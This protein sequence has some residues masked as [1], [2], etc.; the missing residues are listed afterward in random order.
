MA[1]FDRLPMGLPQSFAIPNVVWTRREIENY[2]CTRDVL[3]RYAGGLEPD[4]LVSL[5]EGSLHS[6]AM[7]ESIGE[8]EH[9]FRVLNRDP[10]SKDEKVSDELLPSV[11]SNYYRRLGLENRMT[12]SNFHILAAYLEANEIDAEIVACLDKIASEAEAARRALGSD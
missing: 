4:D 7:T 6:E 10:W 5:A 9:A 12:K 11:F 1:V 3:L 8:V 2:L